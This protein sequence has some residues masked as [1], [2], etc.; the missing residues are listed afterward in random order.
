MDS[1]ECH[2]TMHH[3]GLREHMNFKKLQGMHAKDHMLWPFCEEGDHAIQALY[4]CTFMVAT[5][6]CATSGCVRM[7]TTRR[8]INKMQY[9]TIKSK[10]V[11]MNRVCML[12]TYAKQHCF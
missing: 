3:T 11:E 12:S 2:Q 4:N 10:G 6:A 7:D 1:L 9:K 8:S 5:K